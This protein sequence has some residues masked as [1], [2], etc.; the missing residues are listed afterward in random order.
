MQK[1]RDAVEVEAAEAWAV[2]CGGDSGGT[3][4][5]AAARAVDVLDRRLR[6]QQPFGETHELLV[7]AFAARRSFDVSVERARRFEAWAQSSLAA[8]ATAAPTTAGEKSVCNTT[9][10]LLIPTV[11]ADTGG[12]DGGGGG[13]G[14]WQ[15]LSLLDEG[16]TDAAAALALRFEL[17][18][19]LQ[20]AN[21][22][23]NNNNNNNA[24]S[25]AAWGTAPSLVEVANDAAWHA[26]VA[27][28]GEAPSACR[29]RFVA[30]KVRRLAT[31][32]QAHRKKGLLAAVPG[33]GGGGGGKV[34]EAALAVFLHE[35]P[36]HSLSLDLDE[37]ALRFDLP[38]AAAGNEGG[39]VFELEVRLC[40]DAWV[41]GEP[42]AA[43]G[44]VVAS[45]LEEAKAVREQQRSGAFE[46]DVL[47]CGCGG[48]AAV[49]ESPARERSSSS[50]G[51]SALPSLTL[52][53]KGAV[54]GPCLAWA[55][56]SK[57][58]KA[59][60]AE[61]K[62]VEAGE[63]EAGK[64]GA[65]RSRIRSADNQVGLE[66]TQTTRVVAQQKPK[67]GAG[68]E[69]SARAKELLCNLWC[70]Q[71]AGSFVKSDAVALAALL[72]SKQHAD[73]SSAGNTNIAL[74]SGLAAAA[75][76]LAKQTGQQGQQPRPQL[77]QPR[78][79]K[80]RAA[81]WATRH[82]EAAKRA[83][84]IERWAVSSKA[85]NAAVGVAASNAAA[86]GHPPPPW[87]E[88]VPAAASPVAPAPIGG[89]GSGGGQTAGQTAE[90]A[91]ST[92]T[93]KPLPPH[94]ELAAWYKRFACSWCCSR[95]GESFGS[96]SKMYSH[97]G[98]A[99]CF[100]KC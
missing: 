83:E 73:D 18:R 39:C 51:L 26:V 79:R 34:E 46:N 5:A 63:E 44:R 9:T 86:A 3:A 10:A 11:C 56:A 17:Q 29:N 24:I 13:G 62:G 4:A 54:A 50:E 99:R 60:S 12:G 94:D 40:R 82:P 80:L 76:T 91:G 88:A 41:G 67:P 66:L 71:E 49:E 84:M 89:G 53:P 97:Q 87:A 25:S 100:P 78:E 22:N 90:A 32:A 27:G 74:L 48:T 37:G 6:R 15:D 59:F 93:A 35:N 47:G 72:Q 30:C 95:C 70:S 75:L 42:V 2:L 55:K 52:G 43:E 1:Q 14:G 31:L 28:S 7:S 38:A 20:Q 98:M 85:K 68:R 69:V 61:S 77:M 65:S 16:E 33:G 57:A 21:N 36:L 81:A 23:N 45:E 58:L 8:V 64:E 92:T 19:T 96:P